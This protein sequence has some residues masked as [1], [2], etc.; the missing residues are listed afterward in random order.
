MYSVLFAY[1]INSPVIKLKTKGIRLHIKV[2]PTLS[3]L[4]YRSCGI[5]VAVQSMR[6][7]ER[8]SGHTILLMC[9]EKQHFVVKEDGL[10]Y[11]GCWEVVYKTQSD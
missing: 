6:E 11:N 8:R 7:R 2:V 4:A 5:I 9:M 10:L 3:F 1:Q